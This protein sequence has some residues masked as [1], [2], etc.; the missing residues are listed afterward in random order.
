MMLNLAWMILVI[1]GINKLVQE[2]LYMVSNIKKQVIDIILVAS[3][4]F[5]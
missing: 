5:T 1:I 3:V 2:L 4:M